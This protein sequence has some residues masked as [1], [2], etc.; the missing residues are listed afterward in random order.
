LAG[1]GADFMQ[2]KK[3]RVLV[4]DIYVPEPRDEDH[5]VFRTARSSIERAVENIGG[6]VIE[7][8]AEALS[9][10]LSAVYS[11]VTEALT[12]LPSIGDSLEL[13]GVSFTLVL[14]STGG[15]SLLSSLSAS[16]KSQV[17]F[18]FSL[19]RKDKQKS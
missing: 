6:K 10:E 2:R 5:P 18:T 1:K 12:K 7:M 8:E 13:E 4:D 19:K 14:D 11:L 16:V 9:G 15:F 3:I 17:G